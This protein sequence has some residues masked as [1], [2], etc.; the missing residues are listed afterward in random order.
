[1]GRDTPLP[2]GSQ[3]TNGEVFHFLGSGTIP[4]TTI[5]VQASYLNLERSQ[6]CEGAPEGFGILSAMSTVPTETVVAWATLSGAVATSV[7]AAFIAWQARETRRAVQVQEATALEGA[8]SRRDARAPGVTVQVRRTFAPLEPETFGQPQ[9]LR[10]GAE[11]WWPGDEERSILL[12]AELVLRNDGERTVVVNFQSPGWEMIGGVGVAGDQPVFH[13][14]AP[15]SETSAQLVGTLTLAQC[16]SNGNARAA[17]EPLPD[18]ISAFLLVEDGLDDGVTD[19]WLIELTDAPL[20]PIPGKDGGWMV[21]SG[22]GVPD[23]LPTAA[24]V[25]R[26]RRY[27]LSRATNTRLDSARTRRGRKR[28]W[29]R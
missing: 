4:F 9:P 26:E 27:Y 8:K 25:H 1:V 21:G 23:P 2:R 17:G 6:H 22:P 28:W 7:S 15:K 16:I 11:Y 14:L 12:R 18:G 24:A 3:R 13:E 29:R 5:M 19:E 10:S 20:T